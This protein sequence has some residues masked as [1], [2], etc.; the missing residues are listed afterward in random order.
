MLLPLD[1]RILNALSRD[2]EDDEDLEFDPHSHISMIKELIS[3][4]DNWSDGVLRLL[5]LWP[6]IDPR[7]SRKKPMS[8]C[9]PL[10]LKGGPNN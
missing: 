4:D 3:E 7:L 5:G 8:I 2:G 1:T 10:Y 9:H 6:K